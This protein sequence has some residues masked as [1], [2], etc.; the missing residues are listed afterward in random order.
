MIAKPSLLYQIR[1]CE[2]CHFFE[3]NNLASCPCRSPS[4]H[5]STYL[6]H[7]HHHR[8]LIIYDIY[9][10]GAFHPHLPF[11]VTAIGPLHSACMA[12]VSL[13]SDFIFSTWYFSCFCN[14]DFTVVPSQYV[15]RMILHAM[16][17][18]KVY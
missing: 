8:L 18:T 2:N 16:F 12:Y 15:K 17:E 13:H 4:S 7:P 5:M 10:I 11:V 1:C 14:S 6:H 9:R 3:G